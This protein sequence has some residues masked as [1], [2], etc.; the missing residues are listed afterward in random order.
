MKTR[1]SLVQTLIP[2]PWRLLAPVVLGCVCVALNVPSAHARSSEGDAAAV[3][4][5]SDVR[6]YT[7]D[8]GMTLIVK[9]DHRAPTVVHMVWVRVGAMDEVDGT[10]GVAHV[11]E[12]M[13][14]KGTKTMGPGDYSKRMAALG[15]QENAF[16]SRDTTAYHAQLPVEHL[17]T[18][19]AMEADRF[20]NNQWADEEFK[21]ELEVVKEERRQRTEESPQAQMIE[22]FYAAAFMA[23]PYRRP[24]VGWMSDL[25]AMTPDDARQFYQRWYV[26]A[27]AAV[28]IVGDVQP[29]AVLALAKK[30]YGQIPARAVPVRK[31]REEPTQEGP[32]RIELRAATEQPW[33]L[34]SWK[35]PRLERLNNLDAAQRD[36]L[37][38][39]ML[40]AVMDG[41]PSARLIRSLVQG[42]GKDKR[43][44]DS[45]SASNG[46]TGRGPQLF[47]MSIIPAAGVDPGEAAQALKD[48]L[49]RVAR[50]G[51][52]AKE[53]QR[54]KTQW[55]ASEVYKR[56]SVMGQAHELGSNWLLG[57]ELDASERLLALLKTITPEEVQSVA[58][59]YFSDETL[60]TGV[61]LP[62][63]DKL[64]AKAKAPKPASRPAIRH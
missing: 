36:T 54:V 41:Y 59:R 52:D 46:L 28:V 33:V 30:T 11:L 7:L 62:D 48:E 25:D 10:S 40:A 39:T 51:I 27:N 31:P 43:L 4:A 32:R 63:A 14:F 9:P 50:D 49:A 23:S 38:L 22:Q 60:T 55:A 3:A 18:V 24:I 56:D 58:Q 17:E 15:A 16:T 35:V 12:H 13:L 2:A 42:E 5:E 44:A 64:A 1:F 26:P 20:A 45:V 53:L 37:A 19:M 61:L 8:N 34:L 21:R 29:D 57:M 6:Q 47:T